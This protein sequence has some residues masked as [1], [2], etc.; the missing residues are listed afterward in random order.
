MAKRLSKLEEEVNE[1]SEIFLC[2]FYDNIPK[3]VRDF[4]NSLKLRT[5]VYIFSG[6]IRDYFMNTEGIFRDIDLIIEDD[7][8]LELD[9]EDIIYY[10]NS[11]GGYKITMDSYTID[12]WVIKKTWALT[13]GQLKFEFDFLNTL[14]QTTFFNFSSIIFS[15]NHREFIIGI[16]F[17]R[18]LRDKK[19]EIVSTKNLYPE[20]CIVNSFYYRD[21]LNLSFGEKLKTYIITNFEAYYEKLENIQV[22]HFKKI[23]YSTDY[24]TEEVNKLKKTP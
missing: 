10:K 9:F 2:Y 12:I 3:T 11:F 19:I 6:I 17:L 18:F 22:K 8:S 13:Q 4:V 21:K 16:N 1:K 23:K 14:P 5:K 20:L 24:L 7:I 15:L